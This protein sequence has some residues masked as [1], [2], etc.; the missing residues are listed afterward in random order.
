M[1]II[2]DLFKQEDLEIL[3]AN[4]EVVK[5]KERLTLLQVNKQQFFIEISPKL[6]RIIFE[7]L[8]LNITTVPMTWIKGD[9]NPHIDKGIKNFEKTFLIYLTD[10][11]GQFKIENVLYPILKNTAY[12]F[13]EGLSHGTLNTGTEP[14]LMIGPM[15]EQGFAVGSGIS[16]PGGTTIYFR[17]TSDVQ[18]SI[19]NQASWINVGNNYPIAIY[20]SDSST[21]VLKIEF[22]SNINLNDTFGGIFKYFICGSEYLQ[23]GS[24][25]L[26]S[27]GT[28]PVITIDGVGNYPGFVQNGDNLNAGYN[29][30]YVYN[31]EVR[32]INLTTLEN[33][34]GWIAKENF[35]KNASENYII[36]CF[37]DGDISTGAGGIVGR[38]AGNG[39]TGLYVK[40]CS[41][42]GSIALS[43]G[44]ILGV[45]AGFNGGF[46]KC[47]SCWSTGTIDQNAGGIVGSS[48][49]NTN[50]LVRLEWCY[51]E[52]NQIGLNSGGIFGN[53]GG[54]SGTAEAD[55][56][57]SKGNIGTDGG[58]IFGKA[59]ASDG[60][61]T[62]ATNCYSSGI[63]TT[64]GTGIY[65][66]NKQIGA[67]ETNCYSANGTWSDS[68]A[69]TLLNGT[70]NP[71]IGTTWVSNPTNQPYQLYNMGYTP[72]TINNIVAVT[73]F[74]ILNRNF[75]QVIEPSDT[76]TAG[77]VSG[78]SYTILKISG[79]DPGSY[80]TITINSTTGIVSTSGSTSSGTYIIYVSNTGSYNL[81]TLTLVVSGGPS[82]SSSVPCLLENT[83]VLTPEGYLDVQN[84]KQGDFIITSDNRQVKIVKIFSTCV[85]GSNETYPCVIPK[86]SI[87]IGVPKEEFRI[88]PF[89][90]IKFDKFWIL[91]YNC[92]SLDSSLQKIKY[93]H[94][95]LPNYITDHLVIN[96]GI[97]VESLAESPRET[98]EYNLRIQNSLG[99]YTYE[100]IFMNKNFKLFEPIFNNNYLLLLTC[101]SQLLQKATQ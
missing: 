37:S 47:E 88:S 5:A 11:K 46:V 15:S 19:D 99:L 85:D 55:S 40:G 22:T 64:V 97:V 48:A 44:G 58:G 12:M 31:L 26:N 59:A 17:Q 3:L 71:V 54:V 81:S 94:I 20:N 39:G 13:S 79:G 1:N 96:N 66:S 75:I 23:F 18:Y 16:R 98:I 51:S 92:F 61:S 69:N 36:N 70:P 56:C 10:N 53:L 90:L 86:D 68:I 49:A 77:I 72:Y 43:A 100:L 87:S 38:Y 4:S 50:G 84:L 24:T 57:Y 65:G 21:G 25:S 62:S 27:D 89:H 52:G 34:A 28:R 45:S 76:T 73:V 8:G 14:R 7:R 91:P 30:I 32:A 67:V 82:P 95:K 63:I 93:F 2:K 35:G 83:K 29:Y 78:K 41:S 6:Q 74:P 80:S 42:S 9:T 60:G 33:Y 101:L